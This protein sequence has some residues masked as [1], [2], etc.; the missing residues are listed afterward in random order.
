M[1]T[2]ERL[3]VVTPADNTFGPEQGHWTYNHYAALP[4]DGQHYEI[5]DGV[6]YMTPPSPTG[7]HQKSTGWFFYHLMTHVQLTGLGEVYVAPFDVELDYK[8]V[9]QPDVFVLLNESKHK[10]TPARVVGAPDLIVEISSP[11]TATHDRSRKHNAYE[12][13]GV[14]EYWIADP[15][16]HTIEV[17]HLEGSRYITQGVFSDEDTLPSLVVPLLPVQV[18]QFF[19]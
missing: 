12:R 4:D 5:V 19:S 16:S 13:A 9:V 18:K 1:T 7:W 10:F 17:L 6:L 2:S 11:S 14:K 3:T 8:T 15:G